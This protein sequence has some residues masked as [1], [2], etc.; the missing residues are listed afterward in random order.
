M[1]KDFLLNRIKIVLKDMGMDENCANISFSQMQNLADFQTSAPFVL[2]KMAKQPPFEMAQK[3][4]KK[5]NEDEYLKMFEISASNPGFVN[6]K[7]TDKGISA[8]ANELFADKE[9]IG[10]ER[11]KQPKNIILDYGGANVAKELHMGHL[12][13]PIIGESIKRLN[14]FFGNT[15]V[16]DTHLGDWGLQMG[17]TIAEL[18][19]QGLLDFYFKPSTNAKKPNITLDLLN[20]MY[21]KASAKSKVDDTFKKKADD[22]TLFLQQKRSP[23]YEIWQEIRKVSVGKIEQNYKDLNAEF[24]LWYGESTAN[25]YIATTLQIFKDKNL[26]KESNG[27]LV[28][29]VAREGE[30]IPIPKQSEDEVQRYINPMPPAVIQK[31]NGGELYITTDLA[32]IY[33]R[34]KD[35]PQTNEIVYITDA[36]QATHFEQVFRC[37]RLAGLVNDDVKLVHVGFGTM[38]GKDGK[39]FKTRNGGMIKLDDVVN[40]LKEKANDKLAQNGVP[41]FNDLARKIGVAAMKFGDLSNQV[42]KDYVLDIDKFLAFEGKTGPYL[43]YTAT[44]IKSL[45]HKANYDAKNNNLISCKLDEEHDIVMNIIKLQD[46]LVQALNENSFHMVC[47]A[48]FNLCS[49]YSCFYNNIRILTEKDE[50][51]KQ[52][53][54]NLSYL[55]YCAIKI[56]L[57]IL[58]I[59]IPDKM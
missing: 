44:R 2:A 41:D 57:D 26:L 15:C 51:K 21:P 4:A 17:L 49:A 30:H 31:H 20:E 12:R 5:L 19:E 22:Y 40:L 54:L 58:A 47:V 50:A 14:R 6:F 25:P 33:Q 32:T 42:S 53:Y 1:I 3:L 13:S 7:F 9:R 43:Q 39:P 36:R 28:V 8:F 27:A 37:A 45:L 46:A 29:E 16:A 34:M 56:G 38:N 11:V 35:F 48:V 18:E 24:D 23:F 10:I 55:T 59:D 52:S